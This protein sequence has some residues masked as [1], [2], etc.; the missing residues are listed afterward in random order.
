[1]KGK[2][3]TTIFILTLLLTMGLFSCGK[4]EPME[5]DNKPVV[6]ILSPSASDTYVSGDTVQIRA[7]ITDNDELHEITAS[8]NRTHNGSTEE[9]WTFDE[10]SHTG[11]YELV[12]SYVV[13]VPGMGN[14]FELTVNAS[15][16]NAN[17]GAAS[18]SFHVHM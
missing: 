11:T 8:L 9:V 4:D 12:G 10:H 18:V 1:M 16:H 6:T 17:M 3:L 15:D 14:D 13:A 2:S 5:D 7:M